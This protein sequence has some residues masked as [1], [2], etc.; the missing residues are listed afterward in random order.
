ME[1]LDNEA[2]LTKYKIIEIDTEKTN[3]ISIKSKVIPEKD[4]TLSLAISKNAEE[5]CSQNRVEQLMTS[6]PAT[7]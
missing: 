3:T 6:P 7:M 5:I 2:E 1:E 4:M